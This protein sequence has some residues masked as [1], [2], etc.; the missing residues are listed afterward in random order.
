MISIDELKWRLERR[1]VPEPNTGC[2]LWMGAIND[3]GYG[4][5]PVGDRVV[6]S[7]HRASWLAHRGE[8]PKGLLVLHKCDTRPCI[9]P[10]HLFLGDHAANARDMAN[11]KRGLFNRATREQRSE[12]S[13]RGHETLG[14]DGASARSRKIALKMTPEQIRARSVKGAAAARAA[15]KGMIYGNTREQREQWRQ[16][17]V[18][19][20][21]AQPAAV[22]SARANNGWETRRKDGWKTPDSFESIS[23]RTK[24]SAA[25]RIANQ[26]PEIRRAA[27]LKGW[28]TR[29]S[30]ET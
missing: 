28:I 11:K 13:K 24:R 18:V 12:W 27:A 15:G 10:D 16:M 1:S 22:L 5:L 30:K 9:N 25:T 26:S 8:I 2:W 3:T 17:G 14:P 7:T 4:K 21:A 19:A 29:R 20:A 6:I 23:E